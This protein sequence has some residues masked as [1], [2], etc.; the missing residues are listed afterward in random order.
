MCAA[1]VSDVACK[2]AVQMRF[3]L[4]AR[5]MCG[6]PACRL[7]AMPVASPLERR[8]SRAGESSGSNDM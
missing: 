5:V 2:L 8:R 7:R 6:S 3:R 4:L 1:R